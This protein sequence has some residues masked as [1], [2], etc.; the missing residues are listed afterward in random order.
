[1]AFTRMTVCNSSNQ[2]LDEEKYTI[3]TKSDDKFAFY[4]QRTGKDPT[5]SNTLTTPMI[6]TMIIPMGGPESGLFRYPRVGE[7]VLIASNTG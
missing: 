1:M 7:E 5:T 2:I 6:V 4:V 3:K